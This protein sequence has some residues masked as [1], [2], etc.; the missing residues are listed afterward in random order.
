MKTKE[1]EALEVYFQ[2]ENDY[3]NG[4]VF[5]MFCEGMK[6]GVF[7]NLELPLQLFDMGM[8]TI[9]EHA[10]S[11]LKG[12]QIFECELDKKE[13]NAYQRFFVYEWVHKYLR[14]SEF[15][16]LDL[17]P[18]KDLLKVQRDKL[19][20]ENQP[21]KPLTKNIRGLLKEMIQVELE[22][23]PE[24]LKGLEPKE[25]LNIICKLMPFVLPKVESVSHELDEPDEFDIKRYW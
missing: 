6:Q 24:T 15:E 5:E 13:L 9:I 25:R 10:K 4:F 17:K 22:Q 14:Q 7:E 1:I 8:D 20:V 12:V 3:R 18:I 2:T 19:R 11:P 21:I 16:D 23:L